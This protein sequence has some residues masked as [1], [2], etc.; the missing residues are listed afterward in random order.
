M[1]TVCAQSMA[2]H[3]GGLYGDVQ[4][5]HDSFTCLE[6]NP[7]LSTV[8]LSH[9]T[10]ANSQPFPN[11]AWSQAQAFTMHRLR[12]VIA[13]ATSRMATHYI[14]L[15][16]H[17]VRTT[18]HITPQTNCVSNG[19][20]HLLGHSTAELHAGSTCTHADGAVLTTHGD[21]HGGAH[22]G[23]GG[24]GL[25][26]GVSQELGDDLLVLHG[27]LVHGGEGLLLQDVVKAGG[28]L[29]AAQAGSVGAVVNHE[30]NTAGVHV[31]VQGVHSLN[32]GLIADLGVGVALL[33]Q[34]LNGGHH[35]GDVHTG[36][37]G[38][39]GDLSLIAGSADLLPN[40]PHVGAVDLAHGEA[41]KAAAGL[42]HGLDL[43]AAGHVL[44]DLQADV[45]GGLEA[46]GV[47]LLEHLLAGIVQHVVHSNHTLGGDGLGDGASDALHAL[48]EGLL[49][50]HAL[51]G[52]AAEQGLHHA[53]HGTQQN[54]ALAVDVRLVLRLQGGGE[55]E[56][57]AHTN[58]PAEGN[59]TSSA[60]GILLDGEGAVDA[61]AV[62]ALALLIQAPDGG[63]HTL[64]GHQHN[65]DVL[66]EVNAVVL[67]HAQQ[68]AVGQTQGG[69]RLH[70][71]QDAG[72]Q[73][74]LGSIGNQQ[75]DKVAAG[76]DI[77][78]VT[79]SASGLGEANSLSLSDGGRV[80]A[81]TNGDLDVQASLLNGVTQ[82]LG[83]GWGLGSPSNNT[84]AL[85]ALESILQQRVLIAATTN[86]VLLAASEVHQLLLEHL[87]V[88][89]QVHR[90][91]NLHAGA[92]D[93]PNSRLEEGRA[94][95]LLPQ[96]S[97]ACNG[98][99]QSLHFAISYLAY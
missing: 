56:G 63:T 7:T 21:V 67:H 78:H 8:Q 32:D 2:R 66:A 70:G 16:S 39:Q 86:N 62:D 43:I 83:L 55:G 35:G 82:V 34:H 24:Q 88:E 57:S 96:G 48:L 74:S 58:G 46:G 44:V 41:V 99:T 19:A 76:D 26:H 36:G 95:G 3:W 87:G 60:S 51:A 9:R 27:A 29:A 97:L 53:V 73:L 5:L 31:G 77:E 61:G 93:R 23:A 20:C 84:N 50:A 92:P 85:D 65:V 6:H 79:Q 54:A 1:H 38:V 28:P 22:G 37:E 98:G 89:V 10:L 25:V 94:L 52:V 81:Q 4:Q 69:T 75:D 14:I 64:G 30:G 90:I 47:G 40:L 68:E 42:H 13:A 18:A 45:H 15:C 71:G 59:V 80:H 12:P 72:V 33:T 17:S 91:G 49:V 11:S